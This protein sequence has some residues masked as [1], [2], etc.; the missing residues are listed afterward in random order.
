MSMTCKTCHGTGHWY[1]GKGK[2]TCPTCTVPDAVLPFPTAL[3]TITGLQDD[4][5]IARAEA[6]CGLWALA[7][8]SMP[9]DIMETAERWRLGTVIPEIWRSAFAAGW[10]AS[11]RVKT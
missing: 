8:L 10:R 5:A 9:P 6:D 3:D 11:Q 2:E 1:T 4:L 7:D